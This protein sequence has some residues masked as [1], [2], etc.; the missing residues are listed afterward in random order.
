ML[1]TCHVC[2]SEQESLE[3]LKKDLGDTG[4]TNDEIIVLKRIDDNTFDC[5][6]IIK[7]RSCRNRYKVNRELKLSGS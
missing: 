7:C 2:N 6:I 4:R 3:E 1:T 5:E